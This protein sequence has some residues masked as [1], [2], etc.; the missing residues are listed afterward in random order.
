MM[1]TNNP[2]F[3]SAPAGARFVAGGKKL[4]GDFHDQFVSMIY[5][6]QS[7]VRR[8]ADRSRRVIQLRHPR[9]GEG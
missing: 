8:R 9:G 7:K 6:A 2:A 4:V 3:P 5:K 1:G